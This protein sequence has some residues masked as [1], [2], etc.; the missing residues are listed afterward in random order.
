M[1]NRKEPEPQFVISASA[2]TLVPQHWSK[3]VPYRTVIE[4]I[5]E[6]QANV[7]SQ[8]IGFTT[9]KNFHQIASAYFFSPPP[10]TP[11]H[12]VP[13][14]RKV[15]PNIG[16]ISQAQRPNSWKKY[17]QQSFKSFPPCYS[18]STLQLCLE[19]SISSNSRN[20]LQFLLR[21]KEENLIEKHTHFPMV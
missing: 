12:L 4:A 11:T 10:P 2:S 18:Q 19:I 15:W 16:K 9:L 13:N 3:G 14:A 20:L 8:R 1:V 5:K 21:R 6:E 7:C 17:R